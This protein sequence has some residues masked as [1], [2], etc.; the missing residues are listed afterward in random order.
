MRRPSW[1]SSRQR[2]QVALESGDSP[3][4]RAALSLACGEATYLL[5]HEAH[6]ATAASRK[7]AGDPLEA[8][9]IEGG[10]AAFDAADTPGSGQGWARRP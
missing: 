2:L 8:T 9:C 6:H 4:S 3:V 5:R 1:A 10:E 7:E